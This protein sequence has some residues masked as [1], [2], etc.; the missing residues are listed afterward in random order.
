[1]H[2][3]LRIKKAIYLHEAMNHLIPNQLYI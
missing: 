1:M 3:P 2:G